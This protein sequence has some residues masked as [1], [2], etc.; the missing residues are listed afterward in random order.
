[1]K[2][3]VLDGLTLNPGDNP[4]DALLE[5]GGLAVH[6]RTPP[7]EILTRAADAD[8]LL[9][10]KTVLS[11]ETLDKLPRLKFVSV[12]ATGHNVVDGKAARERGIPVSNVPTYGTDS[13]AQHALAL[14]LELTN[15]VGGAERAVRD[16]RWEACADFCFWDRR[17]I[18]LRGKTLGLVGFGKIGQQMGRLGLALG[19]DVI[20]ADRSEVRAP[21]LETARRATLE[22]LFAEADVVSLHCNQTP[23]NERFVN[24]ALLGRMKP[25]AFLINTARG[26][27][28]DEP[29]LEAALRARKIAGAGLDVLSSEPPSGGNSLIGAP[30]CVITPHVAWSSLAGR[31]RLMATTVGNVRAFLAGA[32]VN[33]VN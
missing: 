26:G 22:T 8:I 30:N 5:F 7:A 6:D 12:L 21:G 33:V 24:A 32:P 9:T 3:T 17:T 27:L 25:S 19:M 28:I 23:E 14:L 20:Y 2:I 10:N 31:R 1:M 15:N 13:V 11:R 16:G 29:A 18:E 4:W